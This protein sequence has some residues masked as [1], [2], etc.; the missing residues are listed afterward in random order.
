[1]QLN[2]SRLARMQAEELDLEAGIIDGTL[3]N[4]PS[5]SRLGKRR[6]H[7]QAPNHKKTFREATSP[8]P[9][10]MGA[11]PYTIKTSVPIVQKGPVKLKK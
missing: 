10:D 6:K 8:T 4:F 5:S 3:N 2:G 9:T 1:M 7:N 11:N